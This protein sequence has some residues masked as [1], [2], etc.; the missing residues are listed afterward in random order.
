MKRH[1]AQLVLLVVFPLL[2][3]CMP[4]HIDLGKRYGLDLSSPASPMHEGALQ[5]IMTGVQQ[6]KPEAMYLFGL[7]QFYG[8]GVTQDKEAAVRFFRKAA[9]ERHVDAQFTLGLLHHAGS[10]GVKQD[11]ALAYSFLRAAADKGHADGQW[12]L[13][14][15]LLD[16]RD[17]HT[18]NPTRALQVRRSYWLAHTITWQLIQASADQGNGRGQFHLGVFYEYGRVVPQN[19]T[20]AATLYAHAA[21]DN[22]PEGAFYLGLM[23]AYGRAVT[24]DFDH[25]L[26][27]FKK[28]SDLG[29]GPAKHY[30]GVMHTHGHG[31]DVDYDQALHWF[32]E[33][34]L[35]KDPSIVET[36]V[37]AARQLKTLLDQVA[38]RRQAIMSPPGHPTRI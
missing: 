2:V 4:M 17:G 22:V 21:A 38:A 23:H 29:H 24:Q 33:A 26:A 28:A 11:S 13:G 14:T 19:L 5:Q 8:H 25:A 16:G 31:V 34:A 3:A 32:E 36:S 9:K 20:R 7:M 18:P 12:F 1:A 10:D 15:M 27:L 35:T 30:L 6:D 37:A